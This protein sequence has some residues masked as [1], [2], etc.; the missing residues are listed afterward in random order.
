M[1]IHGARKRWLLFFGRVNYDY[2]NKYMATA[3]LRIDGS[4]KFA[5]GHRWGYFPSVS[6]GWAISEEAFMESAKSWM[7]FLKIRASWGQNGNQEIDGF[8]YL[9]T[10]A[11]GG[12]DYTFGPDKSILTPEAILIFWLIR[13]LPGDFRAVG[14]WAGC[15]FSE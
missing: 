12:A 3:V 6:A 1:D 15:A 5:R 2:A 8:Q 11:F 7:D 13:M 10:I 9:S 4:S 14:L